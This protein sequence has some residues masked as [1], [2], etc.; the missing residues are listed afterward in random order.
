MAEIKLL[1]LLLLLLPVM[2]MMM[3]M[4]CFSVVPRKTPVWGESRPTGYVLNGTQLY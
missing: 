3:T 4:F 1:V 2:M